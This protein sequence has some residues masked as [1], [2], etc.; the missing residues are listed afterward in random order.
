MHVVPG[1]GVCVLT[2]EEKWDKLKVIN[3]KWLGLVEAGATLLNHKELLTDRGFMVYVTRSYP[4]MVP[5]LKGFHLTIE[6]WQGNRD[7]EGWKLS[8]KQLAATLEADS[9]LGILDDEEAELG[10]VLRK[11]IDYSLRAPITGKTPPAPRL[12]SDLLV[13]K[14]LTAS[15]LPPLRIVRSASVVQV[16]YGFGDA[17]GKGL[18]STVTAYP[19]GKLME[20][21]AND[22]HFCVGIW[23][24]DEESESSNYRELSNLVLTV[25]DEA[26]RGTLDRA[27]F[28]LFPV[29]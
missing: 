21:Q 20:R 22:V 14:A 13:L 28:F 19:T 17:S 8:P 23:G 15:P 18:G 5:Y 7:A 2:S 25:E 26:A 24:S 11:C 29:H 6:I 27:E 16:L 12:L 3:E 4:G 1:I 10:Y 9:Q